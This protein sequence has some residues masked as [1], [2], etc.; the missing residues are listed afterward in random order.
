MFNACAFQMSDMLARIFPRKPSLG[1]EGGKSGVQNLTEPAT[2]SLTERSR[3]IKWLC[4]VANTAVSLVLKSEA[5]LKIKAEQEGGDF[6]RSLN[7][8]VMLA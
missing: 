3:G 8:I 2:V 4:L 5:R 1:K 7:S 6:P